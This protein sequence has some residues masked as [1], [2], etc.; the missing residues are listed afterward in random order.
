MCVCVCACLRACVRV[1][2]TAFGMARLGIEPKTTRPQRRSIYL[3]HIGLPIY[4]EDLILRFYR[5]D[6]LDS[7]FRKMNVTA[8]QKER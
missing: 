4:S 3:V 1:Y 5:K 8:Q 6:N 7:Y 2:F